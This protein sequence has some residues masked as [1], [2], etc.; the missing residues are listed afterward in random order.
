MT[1][2][3]SGRDDSPASTFRWACPI[4]GKSGIVEAEDHVEARDPLIRHLRY[5]EGDGHEAH[6]SLPDSMSVH[7][8]DDHIDRAG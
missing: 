8:M 5:T 4:C 7:S 1:E 6:N 2:D 3:G